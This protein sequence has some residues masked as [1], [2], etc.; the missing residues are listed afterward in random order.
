MGKADGVGLTALQ[1]PERLRIGS[2]QT[3]CDHSLPYIAPLA[4]YT[5]LL[6]QSDS[7]DIGTQGFTHPTRKVIRILIFLDLIDQLCSILNIVVDE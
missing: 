2:G 5:K 4:L 7:M 3:G 1:D 6:G